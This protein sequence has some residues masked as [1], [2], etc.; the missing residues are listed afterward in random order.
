MK[1]IILMVLIA[2][3]TQIVNGQTYCTSSATSTAHGD[4]TNVVFGNLNNSSV[5]GAL[6]PGC[7][8]IA[9]CYS[10]YK[11]GVCA[12]TPPNVVRGQNV[13]FQ[14]SSFGW[15]SGMWSKA[16]F[17][18]DY[19]QNGVFTD[20]GE[21]LG[22]SSA[23]GSFSFGNTITI[24]TNAV[25][26]LTTMRIIASDNLAFST[27]GT[28]NY[29]ETEDYLINITSGTASN[30][31]GNTT[32]S[33]ATLNTIPKL[34]GTNT[35][36]CSQIFDNGNVG[37]GTTNPLAKL[38]IYNSNPNLTSM[39]MN[40]TS[41]GYGPIEFQGP[42]GDISW[43]GGSDNLFIMNNNG[44]ST[45]ATRFNNNSNTLMAIQNNGNV[46]IGTT[47][48]SAKLDV[49]GQDIRLFNPSMAVGS[50][51][52]RLTLGHSLPWSAEIK[53]Y[54]ASGQPGLDRVNLGFSTTTYNYSI[55]SVQTLERMTITDLGN[56]GIGTTTPVNKV[57]I[58]GDLRLHNR[59]QKI[60][61]GSG[62]FGSNAL[63]DSVISISRPLATDG[64]LM[65]A[66]DIYIRSHVTP[67]QLQAATTVNMMDLSGNTKMIV[68]TQTGN[69]GIGI[70]NTAPNAKLQ[71]NG[72]V[73]IGAG[74][75]ALGSSLSRTPGNYNLFVENGILTEK[76][77]VAVKGTANWADYVF[78]DNYQ[79]KPLSE[80]EAFVNEHNHLPGI[81]AANEIVNE[82]LD[83]G[84]MQAKQ[85]EK[86][87]ELTL[88]LI[89]M[90]KKI[91][92]LEKE[93]ASLKSSITNAKN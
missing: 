65:Q 79:L 64:I 45:G 74:T 76:V 75:W 69:V 56:V 13:Y 30:T 38:D 37:V 83:L 17:Y 6:A 12:P 36:G 23:T 60:I 55:S 26:G 35:F 5:S 87:E 1:Q 42:N 32:N 66:N 53:A 50:G 27:C 3:T 11:S 40:S 48:P 33:C 2:L 24:P 7:G 25:L 4:I 81:P 78:A 54:I 46:G 44:L 72:G 47:N 19:N 51:Y 63:G 28:Y 68:N 85:M 34:T 41:L 39:K 57:H 20:P 9:S 67:I 58:D 93:N 52:S 89:Q 43:N 84:E 90:N 71:V 22:A 91:E 92:A 61:F 15:P 88:Y 18:I 21:A 14:A 31:T 80:V 70:G 62:G 49:V 86:I 16:E 10:N 8:S 82:G 77:K 73:Y 29:G 59:G